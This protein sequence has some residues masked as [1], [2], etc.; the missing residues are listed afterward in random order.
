MLTGVFYL[1]VHILVPKPP[2]ARIRAVA[3]CLSLAKEKC[4]YSLRS[5]ANK[6]VVEAKDP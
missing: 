2:M 6:A 1:N 5:L 3:A 4:K